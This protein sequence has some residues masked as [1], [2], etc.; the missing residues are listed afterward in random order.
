MTMLR[1]LCTEL[2]ETV[3]V[4]QQGSVGIGCR[5]PSMQASLKL[6]E[7]IS[8]RLELLFSGGMANIDEQARE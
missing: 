1:L 2:A 8:L 6:T 3:Q 7:S 5:S 4:T